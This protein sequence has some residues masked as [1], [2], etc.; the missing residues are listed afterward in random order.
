MQS[1]K[2]VEV[3][4]ELVFL[5]L[6]DD[7]DLLSL[8]SQSHPSSTL[9]ILYTNPSTNRPRSNMSDDEDNQASG[10]RGGGGG[11]LEDGLPKATIAKLINGELICYRTSS[12]M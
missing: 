11:A 1:N 7:H 8:P 10:S 9:P 6:L 4:S 3:S 5:P 2:T 12:R